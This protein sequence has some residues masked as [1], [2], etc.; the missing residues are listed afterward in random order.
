LV[1]G[2]TIV[3]ILVEGKPTLALLDS[4]SQITTVAQWYMEDKLPQIN[5]ED[6]QQFLQIT[7]ASGTCLEY[8]GVADLAFEFPDLHIWDTFPTPVIVVNNTE[9]NKEIPFIIGTNIIDECLKNC[10]QHLGDNFL[11]S[12][13]NVSDEWNSVLSSRHIACQ[14][15]NLSTS[16]GQVLCTQRTV[17]QPR[18]TS[19]INGLTRMHT[20]RN[21]LVLTEAEQEI[22]SLPSG[23]VLEPCVREIYTSDLT[24]VRMGVKVSNL[25]DH[26]ITVPKKTPLC[27]LHQVSA[28]HPCTNSQPMKDD[29]FLKMFSLD[30]DLSEDQKEQVQ[31]MLVRWK[32][33]FSCSDTDMGHTDLVKHQIKLYNVCMWPTIP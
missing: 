31:D 19:R 24:Y 8:H 29:E 9:Y 15:R 10:Y 7:V 11:T 26:P 32:D 18:E 5:I 3:D 21:T 12:T 33:I 6:I 20:A 16:L 1:G 25:T 28:V 14:N 2:A 17:I 13:S 23:L 4:G 30:C 22:S 27:N